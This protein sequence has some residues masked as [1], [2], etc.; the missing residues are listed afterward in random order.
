MQFTHI[1]SKVLN[2]DMAHIY[3]TLDIPSPQYSQD[4]ILLPEHKVKNPG[5]VWA[6]GALS[7]R[8]TAM[9]ED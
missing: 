1:R 7:D 8:N 3:V 9:P 4:Y 2:T 5:F 6:R